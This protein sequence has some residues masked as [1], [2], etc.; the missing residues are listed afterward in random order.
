MAFRDDLQTKL[1]DAP[2]A[3]IVTVPRLVWLALLQQASPPSD[4]DAAQMLADLRL[5]AGR[6]QSDEVGVLAGQARAVLTLL[7][8]AKP[9]PAPTPPV[10]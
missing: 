5:G 7:P 1:T 8:A 10:K 2:D 3:R 9:T 4:P 6:A